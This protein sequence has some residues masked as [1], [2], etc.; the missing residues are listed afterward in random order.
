[1]F[2]LRFGMRETNSIAREE[3]WPLGLVQLLNDSSH[4]FL[5]VLV[6]GASLHFCRVEAAERRRLLDGRGLNIKWNI[7]PDWTG[8]AAQRNVDGPFQVVADLARL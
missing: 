1:L 7:D 2:E 5:Q 8:P 4:L 3:E 6:D